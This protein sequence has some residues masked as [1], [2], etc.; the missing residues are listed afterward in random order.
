MIP[1]LKLLKKIALISTAVLLL[2]GC[3][4]FY[5]ARAAYEESKILLRRQKISKLIESPKVS[6]EERRKLQLVL[7]AREFTKQIGLTPGK[8][9]TLYSRTDQDVLTWVLMASAKDS[10]SLVTW[11]YPIV[12][13]VPYKGYFSKDSAKS[14]AKRLESKG[15]ETYIR[16]ADA[17]STLGWFNDP[18]LSTILQNDDV[19]IVNI[20][21]HETVHATVWIPN[22]VPFNESMANFI[23]SRAAVDFF[24]ARG[25]KDKI[26]KAE[27]S[28]AHT[29]AFSRIING[30]YLDLENLYK[31]DLSKQEKMVKREEIFNLH[32]QP[33]REANPNMKAFKKI[34]NA[35]IMQL[36]IY[37]TEL[38]KFNRAFENNS[39][40]WPEF[41]SYL[42][43]IAEKTSSRKGEIDLFEVLDRDDSL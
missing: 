7:D 8:S 33:L 16:G 4:P 19:Q 27:Q 31:S 11:W 30:L 2:Q 18:V 17:F 15:Y 23:G 20:V 38:K 26:K 1:Q 13:R 35:E 39:S 36:K 10:F 29:L 6:E 9:F 25:D 41:I 40:N 5:V 37:L 22:N 3:N 12:G 34:N 32:I 43:D 42:K 14:A 21:I 24:K 28:F